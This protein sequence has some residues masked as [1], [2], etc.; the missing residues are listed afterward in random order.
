MCVNAYGNMH[1]WVNSKNITPSAWALS[2]R[3]RLRGG[4]EGEGYYFEMLCLVLMFNVHV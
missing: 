4:I 3:S 1:T 2:F